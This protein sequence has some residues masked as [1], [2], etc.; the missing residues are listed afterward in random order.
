M[1][2]GSLVFFYILLG[3]ERSQLVQRLNTFIIPTVLILYGVLTT[4]LMAMFVHRYNISFILP[5]FTFTSISP[6]PMNISYTLMVIFLVLRSISVVRQTKDSILWNVFWIAIASYLIGTLFWITE[7]NF[8]S[9]AG[10]VQY[11]HAGGV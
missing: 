5:P 4:I 8:C 7:K 11:F 9:T 6:L 2:L 1:I 10:I 3:I